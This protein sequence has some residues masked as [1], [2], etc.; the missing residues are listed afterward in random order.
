MLAQKGKDT[1]ECSRMRP[2]MG[3]GESPVCGIRRRRHGYDSRNHVRTPDRRRQLDLGLPDRG[4]KLC[5]E[6]RPVPEQ[7]VRHRLQHGHDGTLLSP[8][9]GSSR[10]R[11]CRSRFFGLA[12]FWKP[13]CWS[14][15]AMR[16][17]RAA[18]VRR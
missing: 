2:A 6:H 16:S 14:R 15:R 3:R 8:A 4:G 5:E 18:A 13:L 9:R 7:G 10:E 11:I 12:R 17:A 1:A